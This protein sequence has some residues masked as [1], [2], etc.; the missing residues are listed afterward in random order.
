LVSLA[1]EKLAL[2]QLLDEELQN[3]FARHKRNMARQVAIKYIYS[4][5]NV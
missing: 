3:A 2:G 1:K 4:Y 5:F